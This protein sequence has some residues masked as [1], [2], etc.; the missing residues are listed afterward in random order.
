MAAPRGATR[1]K[2]Q[3]QQRNAKLRTDSRTAQL[4]RAGRQQL[5]QPMLQGNIGKRTPWADQSHLGVPQY[6]SRASR[7][8]LELKIDFNE[9]RGS[10]DKAGGVQKDP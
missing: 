5:L 2:L 6:L 3:A 1:S 9:N 10:D 7:A 4:L 8:L